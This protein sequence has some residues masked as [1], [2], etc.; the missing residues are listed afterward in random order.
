[1]H[2]AAIAQEVCDIAL[3][4]AAENGLKRITRI[5]MDIGGYSAVNHRQL[6][7]VF[8]IAVRGTPM[9]GCALEIHD[10]PETLGMF[11]RTIEGE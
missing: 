2:E 7:I 1:M 4:A 5:I 8:D 10:L 9:E 11:V 6:G 3:R